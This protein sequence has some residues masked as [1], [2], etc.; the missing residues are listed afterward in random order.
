MAATHADQL[1]EERE[2]Q[3]DGFIRFPSRVKGEASEMSPVGPTFWSS[4]LVWR[5][6]PLT[7]AGLVCEP[8]RRLSCSGNRTSE[9]MSWAEW[10]PLHTSHVDV[11]KPSTLECG[12]IWRE[13]LKWSIR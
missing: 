3:N 6:P 7:A 12:Y 11:L 2:V 9:A 13:P 8:E 10:G 5:P 1:G 4:H